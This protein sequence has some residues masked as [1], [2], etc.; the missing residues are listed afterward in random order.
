M[1]IKIAKEANL[2]YKNT[3]RHQR[4]LMDLMF[5]LRWPMQSE[6]LLHDT[7]VFTKDLLTSYAAY[8]PPH[9]PTYLRAIPVVPPRPRYLPYL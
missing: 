7:M 1:L 3:R 6:G 5:D 8:L 4:H 9:E 2:S